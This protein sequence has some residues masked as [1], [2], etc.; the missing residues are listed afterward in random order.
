MKRHISLYLQ[1]TGKNQI[2]LM[3][4][5]YALHW[6]QKIEDWGKMIKSTVATCFCTATEIIK[7]I[8]MT[9][10]LPHHTE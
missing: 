9:C 5:N 2:S 4:H 7:T 10:L 6:G 3:P 8:S 1:E